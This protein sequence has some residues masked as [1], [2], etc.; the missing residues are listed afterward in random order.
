MTAVMTRRAFDIPEYPAGVADVLRNPSG[1]LETPVREVLN[2][3]TSCSAEPSRGESAG[4]GY[5]VAA[6]L[7]VSAA[8]RAI[9]TGMA[10]QLL[11]SGDSVGQRGFCRSFAV[12]GW[13]LDNL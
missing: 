8:R 9:A 6:R 10:R 13:G 12:A 7:N 5:V 1:M 3:K 4:V 11:E 2:Q